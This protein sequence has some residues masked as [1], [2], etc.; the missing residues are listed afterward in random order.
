MNKIVQWL[1]SDSPLVNLAIVAIAIV[2]AVVA[3]FFLFQV[4]K[5]FS[6]FRKKGDLKILINKLRRPV[7]VLLVLLSIIIAIPLLSGIRGY[8]SH[9][10]RHITSIAIIVCF[11]WLAI[12]MVKAA[13]AI[14]MRQY[15]IGV[16]DNLKARKVWTQL[17]MI[18]R[19][20]TFVILV[21]AAGIILLTF[22]SIKE[23]GISLLTSAGIAGIILGFAAQKLIA[24]VVAGVQIAITQPI[25]IDDVVIVEN[26]W[27]VIEEIRLTYVVVRIWDQ[28]RLV[29]PTTHFIEKPF[30]NWTRTTSQLLGTVFIYVD[31]QVPVEALRKEL[32]R[33]LE[34]TE[35]WDRR[36]NVLQVTDVKESTVE[37]RALM[38]AVD[39]GT[40][41]DLRVY[42]REHLIHFLKENYPESLPR[43]RVEMEKK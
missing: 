2:A 5:A 42:V 14:V 37:I 22:E 15:D 11:A 38:S 8:V 43:T 7:F 35:L 17:R 33:L 6:S 16:K 4:L 28:R 27:G 1:Q 29:V 21:I 10:L 31:Y 34:S 26:E 24:T 39:S 13:R 36:V 3:H 30:Q 32:T 23:I 12:K 25:R 41:F 20:L 18:E 9:T 19:I 40:A